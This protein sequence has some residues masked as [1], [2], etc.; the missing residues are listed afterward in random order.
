MI[1]S[2]GNNGGLNNL[3]QESGT[4]KITPPRG[5]ASVIGSVREKVRAVVLVIAKRTLL[6]AMDAPESG[7]LGCDL[8]LG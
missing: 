2:A 5:E 4:V 7:H 8:R 6:A 1:T 3:L